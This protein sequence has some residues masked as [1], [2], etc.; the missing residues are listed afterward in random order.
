MLNATDLF[1]FVLTYCSLRTTSNFAL[2]RTAVK[3]PPSPSQ[4]PK[5]QT[6]YES[7]NLELTTTVCS[8]NNYHSNRVRAI[9]VYVLR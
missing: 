5:R 3:I 2:A 6:F 4:L 8:S 7:I 9:Y 1:S